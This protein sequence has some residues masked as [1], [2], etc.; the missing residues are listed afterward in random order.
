MASH[1]RRAELLT[2][3]AKLRRQQMDSITASVFGGWTA[4]EEVEHENRGQ[5]LALLV[6]ELE[7]LDRAMAL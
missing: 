5:R 1:K 3:I 4:G 7:A 6:I 2:E